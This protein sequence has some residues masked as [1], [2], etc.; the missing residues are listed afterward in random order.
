[1]TSGA[2]GSGILS[3]HGQK[4]ILITGTPR[5]GTTWLGK[6]LEADGRSTIFMEPL[7]RVNGLRGIR[8][9]F[10]FSSPGGRDY[11]ALIDR[12]LCG[13]TVRFRAFY[14]GRPLLRSIASMIIPDGRQKAFRAAVENPPAVL[15]IKD[16]IACMAARH[17][18]ENYEFAVIFMIKHPLAFYDSLLRVGWDGADMAASLIEQ[19]PREAT[20]ARDHDLTTPAGRAAFIWCAINEEGVDLARQFPDHVILALHED[21]CSDPQAGIDRILDRVGISGSSGIVDYLRNST[22]GTAV[23]PHQ[24][25]LHVLERNTAALPERWRDHVSIADQTIILERTRTLR[26]HLYPSA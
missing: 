13:G 26:E 25:A 23:R 18:I 9:W 8:H 19:S 6:L 22:T 15:V 14:P 4:R 2:I 7:S 24:R 11:I 21:L 17:L 12:F 3:R 10:P 1:M 20:R 5:S 16:P